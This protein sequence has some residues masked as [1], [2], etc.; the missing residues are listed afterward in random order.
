VSDAVIDDK[1]KKALADVHMSASNESCTKFIKSVEFRI[2]EDDDDDD[3]SDGNNNI[4]ILCDCPG[5][6]DS[7][8]VEL[9]VANIYGIVIAVGKTKSIKPVIVLSK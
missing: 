2:A 8:G 6:G 4:M 3:D 7:R 9:E 1:N 5:L